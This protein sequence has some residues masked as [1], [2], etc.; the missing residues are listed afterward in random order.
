M[1]LYPVK[2]AA[3]SGSRQYA[4]SPAFEDIN[5]PLLSQHPL[6]ASYAAVTS[7][8]TAAEEQRED[9][10]QLTDEAQDKRESCPLLPSRDAR[11]QQ[12]S[13][14]TFILPA[15]PSHSR[16]S[17]SDFHSGLRRDSNSRSQL[18]LPPQPQQTPEQL[19]A[20]ATAND[21]LQAAAWRRGSPAPVIPVSPSLSSSLLR[22]AD[23]TVTSY[24]SPM[25]GLSSYHS[26]YSSPLSP[27]A[28]PQSPSPPLLLRM[29]A[30]SLSSL[31]TILRWPCSHPEQSL[32]LLLSLCIAASSSMEQ[33]LRKT[34]TSSL[35]N[36]RA[37]LFLASAFAS[38]LLSCSLCALQWRQLKGAPL[39]QGLPLLP[40]LLLVLLDSC[41]CL[42]LFLSMAVLPAP[43][44]LLLP[45]L[46]LPCTL[47]SSALIHSQHM[48]R[49]PLL[50]CLLVL[51]S[52]ALA[53]ASTVQSL[54][55][56]SSD[57]FS[58]SSR[59]LWCNIVLMLVATLAA[60]ASY[61]SKHRLLCRH[62]VQPQLLNAVV[63]AGQLVLAVVAVPLAIRLQYLGTNR[64]SAAQRAAG[65]GGGESEGAGGGGGAPGGH[66][67]GGGGG[68]GGGGEAALPPPLPVGAGSRSNS[69][70]STAL[71]SHS[72]AG[73]VPTSAASRTSSLLAA[74]SS[75]VSASSSSSPSSA[76]PAAA[77]DSSASSSVAQT[78]SSTSV[79]TVVSS[80]S[81]SLSD[82]S[83]SS[84]SEDS[85]A[86]ATPSSSTVSRSES[87]SSDSSTA[88]PAA[89]MS[90]S[91][92]SS[93]SFLPLPSSAS[94]SAL[95]IL[96]SL[97][98]SS[99]L[100]PP[101]SLREG[102]PFLL[103]M[104]PSPGYLP[105]PAASPA[106]AQAA[107]AA[108]SAHSSSLLNLRDAAFCLVGKRSEFGDH[109]APWL[110]LLLQLVAF[111]AMCVLCQYA[112][113]ALQ[114]KPPPAVSPAASASSSSPAPFPLL[115]PGSLLVGLL[116]SLASF[117]PSSPIASLLP[118]HQQFL[119]RFPPLLLLSIAMLSVGVL[120]CFWKEEKAVEG[121]D[122]WE[123]V[124]GLMREEEGR[125]RA[126]AKSREA[127]RAGSGNGTAAAEDSGRGRDRVG[128]GGRDSRR[129]RRR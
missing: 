85:S 33:T 17:R 6:I 19:Q 21:K 26:D 111:V 65:G 82:V 86:S 40:L 107:A 54:P 88:L 123:R 23:A 125:S 29:L 76:L 14:S 114:S 112:M 67:G 106:A 63:A 95:S 30:S 72:S 73:H 124:E 81:A 110:S 69:S 56:S 48:E 2:Y 108:A 37:A 99:S 45:Q 90:A 78:A 10:Q 61:H 24:E 43:L 8:H 71:P 100:S 46:L 11:Q 96:L 9:E 47:L 102:E 91:S 116:L 89:A 57:A 7:S 120:L 52:L 118:S 117:L 62:S 77:A 60:T 101:P 98:S 28:A 94:S 20:S 128:R 55:V 12:Q 59:E 32:L 80:S 15:S 103:P 68:G 113:R 79:P 18:S 38:C 41:H 22:P 93:R 83:S 34:L 39:Q 44:A 84:P 42:F 1:S 58:L 35:Y 129:D 109:C 75:D 4:A 16:R 74:L 3:G 92:S 70:S 119:L 13:S 87:S 105:A 53:T 121:V 127:S 36:Y 5:T 104:I 31:V 66:E 126:R 49:A 27:P 122:V 25:S 64:Y 51:L 97:V 115:L 50:G